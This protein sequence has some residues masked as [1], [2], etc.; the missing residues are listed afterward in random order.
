MAENN[1]EHMLNIANFFSQ[2]LPQQQQQLLS[3]RQ[4][5]VNVD[6]DITQPSSDIHELDN[7]FEDYLEE[8]DELSSTRY[9]EF[10]KENFLEE[11]RK[12]KCLWNINT[13]CYK[14]RNMKMNAWLQI[15]NVFN[16]EGRY[17]GYLCSIPPHLFFIFI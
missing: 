4:G 9:I 10:E 14:D 8:A 13:P 16:R 2:L 12:Y 17:L 1:T 5:D 7:V 15:S 11:I 6:M 3:A